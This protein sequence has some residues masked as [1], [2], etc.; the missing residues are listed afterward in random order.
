MAA[1]PATC[2]ALPGYT[3]HPDGSGK[4]KFDTRKGQHISIVRDILATSEVQAAVNGMDAQLT[5]KVALGDKSFLPSAYQMI[6]MDVNMDGIISS[7]DVSQLNQRSIMMIKEFKQAWNYNNQGV[8]IIDKP[9]NDWLFVNAI[10]AQTDAGYKISSNYPKPDGTGFE[11]LNVPVL[12]GCHAITVSDYEQCPLINAETFAGIMLGD[13]NGNYGSVPADGRLKSTQATDGLIVFDMS[14]AI[15]EQDT[16]EIPV[17]ATSSQ[18]FKA[19]DFQLRFDPEKMKFD[20]IINHTGYMEPTY[21]Y[22]EEDSTL[23]FTSYSLLNYEINE[24]LISIKFNLLD[25][26]IYKTDFYNVR[27]WL[28]G[29]SVGYQITSFTPSTVSGIVNEPE[30][31]VFPNPAQHYFYIKTNENAEVDIVD[32]SGR[33]VFSRTE[34]LAGQAKEFNVEDLM[35]GIYIVRINNSKYPVQRKLVIKR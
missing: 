19:M 24:K 18:S 29:D 33:L 16:I 7:G 6:A 11:K 1:D 21:F 9:S 20:S 34:L 15:Q 27:T 25:R 10:T 31:I 3:V 14:N 2:D 22:N 5:M 4:F 35:D 17:Y 26:D 8:K 28:N 13:V 30:V 12:P 32:L 23:R